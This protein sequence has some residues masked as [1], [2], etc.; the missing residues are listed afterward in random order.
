MLDRYVSKVAA[1]TPLSSVQAEKAKI[2]SSGRGSWM[3][4]FVA[5]ENSSSFFAKTSLSAAARSAL[6]TF[7]RVFS[8]S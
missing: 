6:A 2:V 7:S 5:V 3:G 1:V 4:V 8:S